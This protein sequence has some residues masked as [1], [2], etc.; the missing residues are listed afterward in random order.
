M[1]AFKNKP[2]VKDLIQ[3]LVERLLAE[4]T[5]EATK[6][7]FCDES[8]GKATQDRDNR[9]EEANKLNAQL[10]GLEAKRD[11]LEADIDDLTSSLSNLRTDLNTSTVIRAEDKAANLAT[12]KEAKE[13]L[14]ALTYKLFHQTEKKNQC[15]GIRI[16][17]SD[18]E[19]L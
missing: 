17:L 11:T 5:A 16:V 10:A 8:M 7:G 6:K 4:S 14:K 18:S 3:K 13:G 9:F 19:T 12:V 1:V 2:K 15:I